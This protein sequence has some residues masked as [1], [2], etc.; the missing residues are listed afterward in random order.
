MQFAGKRDLEYRKPFQ[1]PLQYERR[2]MDAVESGA[3]VVVRKRRAADKYRNGRF[4]TALGA[5][6]DMFYSPPQK[7]RDCNPVILYSKAQLT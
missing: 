1:G 7:I 6:I 2:A 5:D 4:L 3:Q